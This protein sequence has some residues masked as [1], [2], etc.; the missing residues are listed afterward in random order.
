LCDKSVC[1]KPMF[2]VE[3]EDEFNNNLREYW[4]GRD[5]LTTRE[6]WETRWL[7]L[8]QRRRKVGRIIITEQSKRKYSVCL[9]APL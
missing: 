2:V 4:V 9:A 7:S 6:E 5:I 3:T 8:H 1:L